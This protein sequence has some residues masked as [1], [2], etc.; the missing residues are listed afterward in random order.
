MLPPLDW[1]KIAFETTSQNAQSITSEL[2]I[3]INRK[4]N[5]NLGIM[6]IVFSPRESCSLPRSY[7]YSTTQKE[8]VENQGVNFNGIILI[9]EI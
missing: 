4:Q 9:S 8:I 1:S 6:F 2:P 5:T 3:E 7:E